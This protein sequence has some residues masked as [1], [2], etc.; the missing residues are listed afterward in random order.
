MT[1]HVQIPSGAARSGK[2]NAGDKQKLRMLLADDDPVFQLILRRLLTRWGYEVIVANDGASAWHALEG[3][4]P[5]RLALLDW[6]M[7]GMDGVE[8]CERTRALGREPYTYIVLLSARTDSADLVAAMDAG[9]DDYLTKPFDAHELRVRLRAGRRIV[10]LQE[11]LLRAREAMREQATHDCLTGVFNRRAILYHLDEEIS[12]TERDRQPL[13]VLLADIDHFKKINDTYGHVVGD[14]VL[15]KTARRMKASLRPYDA[16]GRYGG[17]EFLFV[18]PGCD[19]RAARQLA[20]RVGKA[21]AGE[22]FEDA[23]PML[24]VTCSIGIS[25]RVT[26]A[27]ANADS[28]VRDADFAL[29]RAKAGGRNRVEENHPEP[30]SLSALAQVLGGSDRDGAAP[31]AKAATT[32]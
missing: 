9:A 32:S 23:A 26:G 8:I 20:E 16:V 17:E 30:V 10:E 7:P 24:Q 5:P 22:Q 12:R 31:V 3:A 2:S 15:A 6:M 25:W 14:A 27:P 21:I 18:L 1:Q 11:E 29:Y 13:A 4:D 28:L 19:G